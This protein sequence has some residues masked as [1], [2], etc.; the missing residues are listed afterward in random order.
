MAAKRSNVLV[1][2]GTRPEAIKMFPIVLAFRRAT[3]FEPIVITTGQHRDLVRPILDL[4]DIEPD[5]DL[6]VGLPGLTL[7]DLVSSV[8]SR[9]DGFCR[10]R[11]E[12]TGAAVAT[13]DQI[14]E[15]GFPAGTL[16]HGDTSSAAAAAQTSFNLRIPVGHVEAGLR[17]GTTLTPFPEEL[18]RQMISRI[19]AFHLAPTSFN[20]QNLVREGVAD[21]RIFV[22]GNTG[23]DALV[24][25]STHEVQF[26]DRA[27][28]SAVDS[29]DP[30]VVVTAHR[31]EN[32]DGGLAKIA[33]AIGRLAGGHPRTR[34]VIPLH[35]NP[36][37][38]AQLGEPLAAHA[39]VVRTEPLAYAQFA[40]L[41]AKAAV[42]ITDSGGIQEEA[43]ALGVPVLVARGSTERSEGVAAGT[44][45]LVGVD[46]DRIVHETDAVLADPAKAAINPADNPYGDGRAAERIVAAFEYLAGIGEPPRR[47]GPAFSRKEVL[48]ASGYPFGMYTTPDGERGL[49]PDRTEENDS[50]VGRLTALAMPFEGLPVWA[51]ALFYLVFVLILLVVFWTLV[52]FLLSRKALHSPPAADPEIRDS[53]LWVFFVPALNEEVTIS[54]SVA[55]LLKVEARNKAVLV[56]DDGSTDGTGAVLDAIESPDLEVLH[57]VPPDA[58]TGKAGALNAAWH[59]LDRSCPR[60]AGPAGPA[61]A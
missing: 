61:S 60:A 36:L 39:N 12:A 41:M 28:A 11:F 32:W 56:I 30:Y 57:R 8:I 25:A 50:W 59:H 44:L 31:R 9:L 58:R 49:Q 22:T 27:V 23:I 2:M 43:P 35:P 34:F 38:R 37:V 51:Q 45:R 7:N 15:G 53:F 1:L 42:I 4:A 14:R 10:H 5:I 54:D 52:L 20:R 55:R 18:N 17:T 33:E 21:D 24:Y 16:V 40:H 29:G 48:E 19:A 47:F 46:S 6:E 26:E 13:P 3:R